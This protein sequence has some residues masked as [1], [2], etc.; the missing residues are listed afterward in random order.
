[1][2]NCVRLKIE[3]EIF[4]DLRKD[5]NMALQ[6]A[7]KEM[8]DK[9]SDEGKISIAIDIK[10][11]KERIPDYSSGQDGKSRDI[12]KPRFLHKVAH[13]INIK[14]E[15]KGGINPEM[16]MVQDEEDKEL[17]LTYVNNTEQRSIF[18][19]DIQ[20]TM[21]RNTSEENAENLIEG[22]VADETALPGP[23]EDEARPSDFDEDDYGYEE[24][25]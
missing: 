25:L 18:D 22:I 14:G 21:N 13:A 23:V 24:G 17:V 10:L 7:L 9:D 3:G 16:A 6:K 8:T 15:R 20:E 1:M 12:V 5:I 4:D 11:D 2:E 19:D